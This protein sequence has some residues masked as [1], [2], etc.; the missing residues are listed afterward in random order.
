M[1]LGFYLLL[2]L[3]LVITG[4]APALARQTLDGLDETNPNAPVRP[5]ESMKDNAVTYSQQ[6]MSLM[7]WERYAEAA[8]YFKAAIQL[9]PYSAMSASIYNNLGIAYRELGEYPLAI[10]SFQHAMRLQPNYE[11]YYRNLIETY[12]RAGSLMAAKDA[13]EAIVSENSENAEVYYL[14]GLAFEESGDKELAKTYFQRYLSLKPSA[15]MALAAK[16]H[17]LK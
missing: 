4:P 8:G 13:L 11:I 7:K 5:E 14:L 6:G 12:D 17:L 3:C 15:T 16:K 10:A 1:R 9:N 2:I